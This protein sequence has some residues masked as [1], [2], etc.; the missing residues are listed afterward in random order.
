M[1]DKADTEGVSLQVQ[2]VQLQ[3]AM[4]T[5]EHLESRVKVYLAAAQVLIQVGHQPVLFCALVL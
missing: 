4:A 5:K 3:D 2:A 1:C